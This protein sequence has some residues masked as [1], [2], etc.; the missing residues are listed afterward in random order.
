MPDGSYPI[1]NK[2]DLANA[3]QAIG[4]AK[5]PDAVKAHIR[6]RARALDATDMIPESWGK[7]AA[8]AEDP[9]EE[10]LDVRRRVQEADENKEKTE[11]ADEAA[12]KKLEEDNK[13]KADR[14]V[15]FAER[16][17]EIFLASDAVVKRVPLG[18]LK[19]GNARRLL[20]ALSAMEANGEGEPVM[21]AA[22]DGKET[23]GSLYDLAKAVFLSMPEKITK[24]DGTDTTK[25][26]VEEDEVNAP[27]HMA[28][29]DPDSV[30]D[31]MAAEKLMFAAKS[32]GETLTYL[33]ALR[34]VERRRNK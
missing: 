7:V 24:A 16:D 9:D 2:S 11:M 1:R 25:D 13:A 14:L 27:A 6:K 30:K 20:V 28:G 10:K 15:K 23:Q 4:R 18:A 3:I 17:V 26:G 12:I 21:L 33:D 5:N 19:S 32:K 34:E 31:H 8:A 29:A 22:D